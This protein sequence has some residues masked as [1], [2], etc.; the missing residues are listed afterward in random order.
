MVGQPG[1][2]GRGDPAG[3]HD[4]VVAGQVHGSAEQPVLGHAEA[5]AADVAGA[6]PAH[7]RPEALPLERVRRQVDRAGSGRQE[8]GPGD[9]RA[10]R[11][12]LRKR[13]DQR[14]RLGSAGAQG[15]H[16]RR[17]VVVR[18]AGAHH[19]GEHRVGAQFEEG[20]DVAL[21][22]ARDPVGEPDG[23]AYVADPVV[24]GADLVGVGDLPGQVRHDRQD[25]P[26]ERQ[27]VERLPELG[28][29][30]LHERAV[31]R[32]AD[33]EP[34][35][36][37]TPVL[38]GPL[39]LVEGLGGAGD[40]HGG[41]AVDGGD[42]DPVGERDDRLG[43]R[44]LVGGDGEHAAA[45]RQGLHQPTPRRDQR[46][47]V[48]Q[49]EHARHVRRR[50]LTDGVPGHQVRHHT[51]RLDQPEQRHLDREQPRL[52]EHR[53]IQQLRPG[54]AR[55]GEQH[56]PQRTRQQRIQVSTHLVQGRGE[57]RERPV[58]PAT[59]TGALRALTGEE[60]GGAAAAGD[61]PHDGGRGLVVGQRAEGGEQPG[62][63]AG[64]QHGAVLEGAAGGGERPADVGERSGPARRR[65]GSAAGVPAR[66]GRRRRGPT[67]RRRRGRP[68]R[69][70]RVRPAPGRA[71]G[72]ARRWCARWC[73]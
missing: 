57:H 36:T 60:D 62:A 38:P 70:W 49:G 19:A 33:G 15:R 26:V 29:H 4:L 10:V 1:V 54:R 17:R 68:G 30:R 59:H 58:Q 31:E 46:A 43:H 63:V 2:G 64:Q 41:G 47:R 52:R 55:R 24:G 28:Q 23:L 32:V 20:T 21:A 66:A 44:G 45:R 73:R 51:Q 13:V 27:P 71:R 7:G 11:V 65:R 6:Q 56:L 48:G 8:G 18:Q 3:Q 22:Q 37:H 67:G 5:G 42:A 9:R 14:R 16:D 69:P 61:P 40:H 39:H 25:G 12:Q 50:D 53:L 34:A 72:P 35:R